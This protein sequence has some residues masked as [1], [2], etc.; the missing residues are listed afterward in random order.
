MNWRKIFESRTTTPEKAVRAAIKS[1]NRVFLT[2]NCSIPK[3]LLA[4]LVE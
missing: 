2:G 4:A 1:G 3:K